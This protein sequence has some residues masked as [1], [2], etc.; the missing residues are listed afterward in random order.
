MNYG[1]ITRVQQGTSVGWVFQS[2]VTGVASSQDLLLLMDQLAANGWR[3]V[4]VGDFGSG[5]GDE[6]LLFK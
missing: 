2:H 5:A 3:V 6:F 1:I 4:A